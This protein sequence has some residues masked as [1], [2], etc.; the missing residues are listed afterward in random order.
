MRWNSTL[1]TCAWVACAGVLVGGGA[2]PAAECGTSTP[3]EHSVAA[4]LEPTGLSTISGPLGLSMGL[5]SL[6]PP[7]VPSPIGIATRPCGRPA[8]APGLSSGSLRNETADALHGLQ[9]ADGLHS[10]LDG[11]QIGVR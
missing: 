6:A 7:L 9:P 3:A 2:L 4:A 1:A 10:P 5:L 11:S 8:E